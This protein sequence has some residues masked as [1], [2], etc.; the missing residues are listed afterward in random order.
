MKSIYMDNR[1]GA[2]QEIKEKGEAVTYFFEKSGMRVLY[3]FIKRRAGVINGNEYFDLVTPRGQCGPWIE[4]CKSDDYQSLVHEF[5]DEFSKY[6]LKENIVAEYVRFSPWIDHYKYFSNIYDIAFHGNIYCNDLS[7]D[8]FYE[9]YNKK[10]RNIVRKADKNGVHIRFGK[11]SKF[12]ENF[13]SLYEFTERKYDVTD[14][15]SLD[16]FIVERYCEYLQSEIVFVEA[17][18]QDEIL[19]SAIILMGDD[20]AHYHFASTHPNYKHLDANSLLLYKAALYAK[21]EGKKLFDLG[22]AKAGSSLEKFKQRTAKEYPYYFGTCIRNKE[23][24]NKLVEV[25]GGPRENYFP[26]YRRG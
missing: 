3:P 24:Y 2:L 23:V 26:A 8:F 1:W 14:Y 9:E 20:I 16:R 21:N 22:G 10:K 4:N 15:Y 12:I 5:N 25:A 11:N 13:L 18:F 17:V 19:A 6:C 7:I